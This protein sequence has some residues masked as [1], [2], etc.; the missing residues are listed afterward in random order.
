MRGDAQVNNEIARLTA[1]LK[2]H[3][4]SREARSVLV[5][6]V[7]VLSL[8]LSPE[9]VAHRHYHQGDHDLWMA[10]DVVARWLAEEPGV[11]AP[12]NGLGR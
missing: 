7:N 12:S 6:Q 2:N 10:L 1:V 4:L 9:Q 3:R 8:R 11:N 5:A